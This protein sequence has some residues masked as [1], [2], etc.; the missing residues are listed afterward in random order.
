MKKRLKSEGK[1]ESRQ[2][3]EREES[4]ER[5]PREKVSAPFRF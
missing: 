3:R 1:R 5:Q 4:C 2:V